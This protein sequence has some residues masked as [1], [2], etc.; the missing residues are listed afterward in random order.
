[1]NS[2]EFQDKF[3][4][5]F[6]NNMVKKQNNMR[7][8]WFTRDEPVYNTQQ[9]VNVKNM[10]EIFEHIKEKQTGMVKYKGVENLVVNSNSGSNIYDEDD[11]DDTYVTSDPFSKLKF[12]D[13]RKVHKDETV[14][15]VSERDYSKVKKYTSDDHMMRDRGSQSL[16][17]IEKQEAERI[18]SLQE[19]QHRE[20]IM[21]KEHYANLQTMQY[22]EKNK[23]V[24]S[25]FLRLK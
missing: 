24:I 20:R 22:A 1:M 11:D 25:Q 3:N 21:N 17:P 4:Q 8:D 14:L 15:A 10:G 5:L 9:D 12:D 16:T 18:L 7:N 19:Q 13:L 23:A 6:E 2:T